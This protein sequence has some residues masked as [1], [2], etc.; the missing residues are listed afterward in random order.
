MCQNVKAR[1]LRVCFVYINVFKYMGMFNFLKALWNIC[2]RG[3][4]PL[5]TLH[6][7]REECPFKFNEPKYFVNLSTHT[8]CIIEK[9]VNIHGRQED[10][11]LKKEANRRFAYKL[12]L[13]RL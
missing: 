7:S 5:P 12:R 11:F 3:Q 13:N 1:R 4:N 2:L 10:I 9:T 6:E 8:T